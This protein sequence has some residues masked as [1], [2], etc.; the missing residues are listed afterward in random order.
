MKRNTENTKRLAD[1]DVVYELKDGVLIKNK[2]EDYHERWKN[3]RTY[4]MKRFL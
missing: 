3:M 2:V 4:I 1:V